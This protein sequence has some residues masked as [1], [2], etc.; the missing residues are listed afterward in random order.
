MTEYE[1]ND[2][3]VNVCIKQTDLDLHKSA[4]KTRLGIIHVITKL[5]FGS[6]YFIKKT[7]VALFI[8][9]FFA[10]RA[11]KD[12]NWENLSKM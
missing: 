4:S 8:F 12:Q 2:F 11:L 5:D 7:Q 9:F 6:F 1:E 10:V 3:G